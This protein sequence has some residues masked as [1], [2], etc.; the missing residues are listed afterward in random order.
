VRI[1]WGNVYLALSESPDVKATIENMGPGHELNA[2]VDLK[3]VG[4]QTQHQLFMVGYDDVYSI[5]YFHQRLRP[6]WNRDSSQTIEN[7]FKVAEAVYKEVK[8]RC[9]SFDDSLY[10]QLKKA[11]G[12]KYARLCV[13]AYR[14]SIAA[15][16]LVQS[17]DGELL[18]LS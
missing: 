8:K 11:G 7:Q 18:F 6:W 15:H 2:S 9:D 4:R 5:E 16:K 13:L 3:A 1:D 10:R 12:D 14:Q 17:P